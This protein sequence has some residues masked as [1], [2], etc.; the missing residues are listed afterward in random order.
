MKI[1]WG[2]DEARIR[3]MEAAIRKARSQWKKGFFSELP[4]PKDDY[5]AVQRFCGLKKY[6]EEAVAYSAECLRLRFDFDVHAAKGTDERMQSKFLEDEQFQRELL[7]YAMLVVA[8]VTVEEKL[9]RLIK[10]MDKS[11]IKHG[12]KNTFTLTQVYMRCIRAIERAWDALISSV[13][14]KLLFH[15][16]DSMGTEEDWC[17]VAEIACAHLCSLI[18]PRSNSDSYRLLERESNGNIRQ[19]IRQ[20]TI[21]SVMIFLPGITSYR[22]MLKTPGRVEREL[23]TLFSQELDKRKGLGKRKCTD[24]RVTPHQI[25][26]DDE[27]SES[28]LSS[29]EEFRAKQE[30]TLNKLHAEE[31]WTEAPH[32]LSAGEWEVFRRKYGRESKTETEIAAELG[33]TVGHVTKS[34]DRAIKKLRKRFLAA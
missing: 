14:F 9:P 11:R 24:D 2:L 25:D 3:Q 17:R 23:Q 6:A 8:H 26:A 33:K 5:E 21:S 31:I 12:K 1:E 29:E 27:M 16:A 18:N 13:N 15:V 34:A 32:L 7:V 4:V 30:A 22:E 19:F 28:L 10:Q 20:H